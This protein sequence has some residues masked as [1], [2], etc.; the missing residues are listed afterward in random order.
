MIEAINVKYKKSWKAGN[1]AINL[2]EI[3][4]PKVSVAVWTRDEDPQLNRY[5]NDVFQQLGMGLRGVFSMDVLKQELNKLLP[6]SDGKE[7]AIEDI[8]L[9]SDMLTCLFDCDSVGM[10][11]APLTSA[12]CPNF[13]VDNIPVR[14]VNTY[15]GDGTQWLPN[16]NIHANPSNNTSA[17]SVKTPFG[18]GY[19]NSEIQQLKPFDVA[20][21]KGQAWEGHE[22]M[23]AV[24]RSC[25]VEPNGKRVLLT[26]DPL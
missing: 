8:Y 17:H 4:S 22:D 18:R 21:L 2:S 9:L 12:M 13:H 20:L 14:L 23:A 25:K 10:R 1:T 26:L 15:L 7:V 16:E 3:F 19:N 5:F 6:E 11:I 24:H